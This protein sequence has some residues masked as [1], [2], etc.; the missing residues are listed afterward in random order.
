[1]KITKVEVIPIHLEKRAE[2]EIA[3]RRVRVP[4]S[5]KLW[6]DKVIVKVSTDEDLV[7]LGAVSCVPREWGIDA[8][9]VANYIDTY[10]GPTII[11]EDPFNIEP[12][13]EKM[14]DLFEFRQ[15][16]QVNPFPRSAIDVALYDLMGK[17][18]R[19]P[20][21]KIIGGCYR[22]RV[23]IAGIVYIHTAEKMA[24]DASA[25]A[26]Q[27]FK[28]VK[29]K[30]GVE[31]ETDVHNVKAVREAIGDVVGIRVDANGAWNVNTAIKT[32]KRLEKYDI[33]VVEQPVPRWDVKGMAE[34]RRCVNTPIMV[35]EGLHSLQDAQ[36]LIEHQACDIFNIKLQK[37][38]GL[39]FC[40]K[41]TVMAESADITCFMGS[42][43]ETGIGTAAALHLV[44]STPNFGFCADLCGPYNNADDIIK[45]PFKVK[46]GYLEVPKKLG[47][48]VELDEEKVKK[49]QIK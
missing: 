21:H 33:L 22:E 10:Y 37:T 15:I 46:D 26:S 5:W 29:M 47:L 27:G 20:I 13:L 25:F 48:G 14:D 35:D 18:C 6:G 1:M 34:V 41:L 45:K 31:P 9:V 17:Y 36:R 19:V 24:K 3:D 30:V 11:G 40:K 7:G 8:R 12:I 39:T 43:G 23:S 42:E 49:Y 44:A 38:G 28:E 16:P 32:I 2:V 4:L